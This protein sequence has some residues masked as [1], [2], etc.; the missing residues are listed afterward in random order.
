MLQSSH[1]NY[2]FN[3]K[4]FFPVRLP[5]TLKF[6]ARVCNV[7]KI[8]ST[9]VCVSIDYFTTVTKDRKN[10]FRNLK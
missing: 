5:T 3:A 4:L 7:Q 6:N 10:I 8:E 9:L 2:R 1:Y